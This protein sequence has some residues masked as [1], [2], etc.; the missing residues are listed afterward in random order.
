MQENISILIP[1]SPIPRHPSTDLIQECIAAIRVHLPTA[2]CIIMCDGVRDQVAHRRE[3]YAE[4]KNRLAELCNK[5]ELGNTEMRIFSDPT[6]QCGMTRNVLHH[7]VHTPLV[8]FLEHDAIF[9]SEPIAWPAIFGL[10]LS[11][12]ANMVRF[13]G[14]QDIWHEHQ[15]LM[16]GEFNY[17]GSR[18]VKT[19]QYSQWPLVSRTDYHLN[20]LEKYSRPGQRAM[21]ESVMYGP[22]SGAPWEDNKIVIYLDDKL[23]FG[24]RDG[25]TD[26]VSGVRDPGEW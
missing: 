20:I 23:V 25:R 24:H 26:E 14:W 17:D 2:R 5:K 4:Y 8:L 6:Q 3:Q 13:Y 15:Y 7:H 1:T 12:Q 9:R 21:I 16:R 18:F 10:L 19:V 22:V 11:Q